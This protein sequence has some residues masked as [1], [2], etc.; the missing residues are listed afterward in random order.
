[1]T[2]KDYTLEGKIIGYLHQLYPTT[3][4]NNIISLNDYGEYYSIKCNITELFANVCWEDV[5]TFGISKKALENHW[6]YIAE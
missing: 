2:K 1:M 3:R 5:S 4:I 6:R